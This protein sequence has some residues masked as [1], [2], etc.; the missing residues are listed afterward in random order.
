MKRRPFRTPP[1]DPER[2]LHHRAGV[3]SRLWI[4]VISLA[5]V[6]IAGRIVQLQTR[7][8]PRIE[9]RLERDDSGATLLA[10]RGPL[11]DRRGR[12][13]AVSR[14]ATRLFVDPM[15]IEDPFTFPEML[16]EATGGDPIEIAKKVGPRMRQRYVVIDDDL[17]PE[18]AD[19]VRRLGRRSIGLQP[20]PV[21][22]YPMGDMAG[23]VIG[24]VGV[25][26]H[27]LEG[28]ERV[29]EPRLAG[30][31]GGLRYRRD[32]ARR[33]MWLD[34]SAWREPVNGEAVHLS[35]DMVIQAAAERE[36]AATCERFDARSGQLLVMDPWTGEILAM[37]H[38]PGFDPAAARTDPD[39]WRNRA[40]TDAFEPGSI[41]KPF[42]WAGILQDGHASPE[43]MFDTTES[44]FW[45]SSQ[46]RRLRDAHAHG[47]IT[48]DDVLVFS[49][50]I[51]MAIAAERM[52]RARLHRWV[53][54]FGFGQPPGSELPGE[55][56]G[57]VHPQANWTH[58]SMSSV[59]MG[60][61]IA[62]TPLQLLRALAVIANDGWLIAP[63]LRA[64]DDRH[65]LMQVRHRVL[66]QDVARHTRQVMRRVVLEGTGRRANSKTLEL[67][68]KTGTAQVADPDGGG[69]LEDGYSAS[70]IAGTP[71]DTPRLIAGCFIH[72]PDPEIGHYGGSVAAPA[73]Q[74]VLDEAMAYLRA[75]DVLH[76]VANRPPPASAPTDAAGRAEPA[77]FSRR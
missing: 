15:L 59:P 74:R 21:R 56:P 31:D 65:R 54:R 63:T 66:N 26:G 37:A 9:A 47:E 23:Q 62:V 51:G 10:R 13:V 4:L 48:W 5:L 8:H 2:R 19:A 29:F 50:N 30:A 1:P 40:V 17:S 43:E 14:V 46:G 27:G 70:F 68:G 42:V 45:V 72:H 67:W 20:H 52:P 3:W 53:R 58:Y 55:A 34:Y 60:Q 49:S 24:F 6:V 28:L 73:V 22:D 75:G 71:V 41:F 39:A 76:P 38:W 7:P 11:L 36:L 25:E 12:P 61:E 33:P 57:I 64:S 32:A 44:G 69:Y 16:A 18:A 35:L 77:R